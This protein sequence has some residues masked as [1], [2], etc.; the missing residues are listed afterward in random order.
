MRHSQLML[1][2]SRFFTSREL[3]KLSGRRERPSQV[4]RCSQWGQVPSIRYPSYLPSKILIS[5][6]DT[7]APSLMYEL[8][9]TIIEHE[10]EQSI[11]K[12][13]GRKLKTTTILDNRLEGRRQIRQAFSFWCEQILW[14][15]TWNTV[16]QRHKLSVWR[17]QILEELFR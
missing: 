11:E 10:R 14:W 17:Y 4:C 2:I 6:E 16:T 12:W 13:I 5:L 3:T 9:L 1:W 15:L 8:T 7:R